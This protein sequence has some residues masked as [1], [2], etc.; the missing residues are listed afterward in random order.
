VWDKSCKKE[1]AKEMEVIYQQQASKQKGTQMKSQIQR[2]RD[3]QEADED[4]GWAIQWD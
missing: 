2:D 3:S 1:G 4:V